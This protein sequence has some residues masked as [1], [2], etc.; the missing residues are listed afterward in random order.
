[1]LSKISTKENF[2][3]R[4]V[5][6]L[7]L[8]GLVSGCSKSP[9]ELQKKFMAEGQHYLSEGKTSEAV[10]EF[11]NLLKVNPRSSQGHYWLGKAYM[12]KGW[13]SEAVLQYQEATKED[14]LLLPAHIEL[15][16]YGVN[17]GQWSATKPEID[18]ILKVDPNNADGWAFAGQRAFA[19]GREEE[20]K[21]DLD[22]ALALHPGL[23]SALV[24]MGDL[25]QQQKNS[26]QAQALYKEAINKDPNSSAAWTGLGFVALSQGQSRE[27]SDDFHKAVQVNPSDLRSWID[28]TNFLAQQG[29]VHKAIDTLKTLPA[30][31]TDLR[32]PV[33][34]AEY[35]T[36]IGE[37]VEA[38]R[39]LRPLVRQKLQ[40]PDIDFV[41]AKAYQQSGKKK[42]ALDMVDRLTAM[43]GVPPFMKISSARIALS[44]GRPDEAKKILDSVGTIPHLPVAYWQTRGQVELALN[45]SSRAIRTLKGALATFPDNPA[46]LLSLADAQAAR[47]NYKEA[48]ATLDPLLKKNPRNID[49]IS[50]MGVLLGLTRGNAAEIGYYKNMSQ[51]NPDNPAVETLYTLSLATNDK[52]PEAIQVTN[53]YLSAHP[54]NPDLLFL[55]AQFNL[56]ARHINRAIGIYK[57]IL[58]KN[59]KNLQVLVTLANQEFRNRNYTQAEGLYRQALAVSPD[60]ASLYSGLGQTLVAENKSGEALK[61]FRKALLI[62]PDQPVALLAIAVDEIHTGHSRQALSHLAPLMKAPASSQKKAQIQWLWG[63]ASE[64]GG[65]I[66]AAREAFQNAVNLAP[67][68]FQ[69][70]ESLGDFWYSIARW[71]KSLAEYRK[72]LKLQEDNPLLVIKKTWVKVHLEK[73]KTGTALAKRLVDQSRSYRK[74]HP[75]D[76]QVAQ[77]EAQADLFLKK[78]SDA[79]ALY[80]SIL[81]KQPGDSAAL[82]GKSSILLEQGHKKQ[83]QKILLQVLETQPDNIQ[84]NMMLASI[85]RNDHNLQGEVD[86]LE[87]V[88]QA[89]PD[90]VQPALALT[91]ADLALKRY[92]EARSISF[93]LHEAHPNLA[94]PLLYQANA[95]MGLKDYRGALRDYGSFVKVV[96]NPGSIYSL[97]SVAAMKTGDKEGEKRYLD[98]ALKDSPNDPSILNNMA[99]YLAEN[100]QDLP[101]ALKIAKRAVQLAPRPFAQDTL[102]YI[103]FRMGNYRE[104]ETQ[105][106]SAWD[107]QFRDP[108]FLYHMGMNEWKLGQKES[109]SRLL[110][111]AISS[112]KLSSDE[113]EQSHLALRKMTSGT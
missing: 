66:N 84:A 42:D 7:I 105:F 16:R 28:L 51:K 62:N 111:K 59:P 17:S 58:K 76:T 89:H 96:K 110:R 1:M 92:S 49:A 67:N 61:S 79:L 45:H 90:W 71:D 20:A 32:I 97:M 8:F 77:I 60:S 65:N 4:L 18:A 113:I 81:T 112:G 56:Q 9:A 6:A 30:K 100:T 93:S 11:Q 31:A 41:L 94:A 33:K 68:N 75:E 74:S 55:L 29:H 107:A 27:A 34:I 72:S 48:I 103:L 87:K 47:K 10:I 12:K 82:L 44:E 15:A 13:T 19:L 83:S 88:H 54:D 2:G 73:G 5:S 40:I 95:E 53:S 99:Y 106:K 39:I 78:P 70:H 36:L 52:V 26:S 80:D 14:P 69:Y 63:M 86:H 25:D 102:G 43:G 57:E 64:N 91:S 104:A 46:L 101:K 109:S 98:L 38:I 3:R 21:K 22:H 85:D 50:R 23:V 108:E 37:N 24:A 35:E